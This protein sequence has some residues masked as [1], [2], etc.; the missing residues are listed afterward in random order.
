MRSFP[1]VEPLELRDIGQGGLV[2][3]EVVLNLVLE[4]RKLGLR[5][6]DIESLGN[7]DKLM[8]AL[9]S[10]AASEV[11]A[12]TKLSESIRHAWRWRGGQGYALPI[13]VD[14]MQDV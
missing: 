2:G 9:A 1:A 13:H 6:R 4:L 3:V 11:F 12:P 8:L 5:V 14:E 7:L 10:Q